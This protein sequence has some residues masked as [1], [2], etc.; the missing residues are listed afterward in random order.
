MRHTNP[1]FRAT[2]LYLAVL[3]AL[4]ALPAPAAAEEIGRVI[5]L[6]P[7]VTALRGGNEVPL[8]LKSPVEQG[9][10]IRTDASGRVQIIFNDDSS[11]ALGS[12]ASLGMEAFADN[13]AQP[14]FKARLGAGLARV[15]T[16]RVVEQNPDGFLIATPEATVGIRGTVLA[17]RSETK[18][19][20]VYVENSERK[21]VFVNGTEVPQGFTARVVSPGAP[22]MIQRTGRDEQR[23]LSR[24]TAS[25]TGGREPVPVALAGAPGAPD[26]GLAD[27]NL[28]KLTLADTM[29]ATLGPVTIA[30][31]LTPDGSGQIGATGVTDYIGSFSFQVDLGSGAISNGS[32]NGSSASFNGGDGLSYALSG[33]SGAMSNGAFDISGFQ[34]TL[35]SSGAALAVP[36]DSWMRGTGDVSTPGGTVSGTYYID[37]TTL[38]GWVPDGGTFTGSRQAD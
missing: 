32:M 33:G 15:I 36:P 16:G 31:A 2:P 29:P 3:L 12:N 20:T 6:V 34:G 17:V 38:T 4:S 23:S 35:T 27:Q 26:S 9:D 19:T 30:G 8:A 25:T 11:V 22:P 21:R 7:G 13:G 24:E 18:R 5:T 14:V 37:G 1:R 28:P 10:T